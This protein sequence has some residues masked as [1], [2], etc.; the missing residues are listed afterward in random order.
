MS[1]EKPLLGEIPAALSGEKGQMIMLL[2]QTKRF[3]LSPSSPQSCRSGERRLTGQAEALWS[4]H[5]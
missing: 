1:W 2:G 4:S 3:L 5:W